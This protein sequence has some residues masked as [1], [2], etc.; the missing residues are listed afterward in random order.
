MKTL[1]NHLILFDAECPMCRVY[2][3]VF[4][5][6]GMLDENGRAAYQEKAKCTEWLMDHQE[7]N[8]VI[9]CTGVNRK[10]PHK[11]YE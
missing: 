2:T 11:H 5:K 1:K 3:Q 10:E 7:L 9:N 4:V 6:T 8:G